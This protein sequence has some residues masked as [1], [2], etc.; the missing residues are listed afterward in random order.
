MN[1]IADANGFAVC[2]PQGTEDFGGTTH[3]N[4]D[5]NISNTD[6]K[7][8]LSDLAMFLQSEYLFSPDS[9]PLFAACRTAAS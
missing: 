1:R 9:I 7:G 4:A 8:F 6:D 5:L 3:W 2:Y